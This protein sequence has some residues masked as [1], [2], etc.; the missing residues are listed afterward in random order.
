MLTSLL[1][2]LSE[3]EEDDDDDE[4]E[5][6]CPFRLVTAFL[7]KSQYPLLS[8]FFRFKRYNRRFWTNFWV[9]EP[10]FP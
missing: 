1:S 9:W 10:G 3:E 6:N 2:L 4:E 7:Y 8:C 5:D